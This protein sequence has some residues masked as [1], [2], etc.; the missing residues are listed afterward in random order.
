VLAV[1]PKTIT[2]R[3]IA[4]SE[5]IDAFDTQGSQRISRQHQALISSV[6]KDRLQAS[7]ETGAALLPSLCS[8]RAG[9]VVTGAR[10]CA[11]AGNVPICCS[12]VSR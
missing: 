6:G 11:S 12:A 5:T 10:E 7:R 3:L 2:K 4:I 8:A 1:L 9:S